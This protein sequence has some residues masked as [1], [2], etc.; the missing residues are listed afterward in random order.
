MLK[1]S[2][3]EEECQKIEVIMLIIWGYWLNQ[4]FQ[5]FFF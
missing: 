4:F 2:K 3:V 5:I 1:L